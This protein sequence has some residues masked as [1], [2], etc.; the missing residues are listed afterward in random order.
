MGTQHRPDAA[1][2]HWVG[3]AGEFCAEAQGVRL[4]VIGRRCPLHTPAALR[5]R[6]E[7]PAGPGWPA[8]AWATPTPQAASALIDERA[9]ASGKR[10]STQ[11]GYRAAQAA[12]AG[13]RA[14]R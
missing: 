6:P 4:Y 1:C 5:G 13:R 7:V 2:G 8:H 11:E 10:R 3:T 12:E 9:V 14:G